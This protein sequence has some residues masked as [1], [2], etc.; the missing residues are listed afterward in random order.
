M[1]IK[2][3]GV[4]V[5]HICV[6]AILFLT[7]TQYL[8]QQFLGLHVTSPIVLALSFIAIGSAAFSGELRAQ[9]SPGLLILSLAILA[10]RNLAQ[11]S[12][13]TQGSLVVLP[14]VILGL[15]V[16]IEIETLLRCLAVAGVV[17]I[18]A[19]S[20]KG[21]YLEGRLAL[22]DTNPIWI[23]RMACMAFLATLFTTP[24]RHRSVNWTIAASLTVTMWLTGSRGPILAAWAA[25]LLFMAVKS[26]GRIRAL[27][28]VGILI[29]FVSENEW[30][31]GTGLP[32]RSNGEINTEWRLAAWQQ[33]L[34]LWSSRPVLGYGVAFDAQTNGVEAYPHNAFIELL[35]QTGVVGLGIFAF[36]LWLTWRGN[37][38]PMFRSIFVAVLIFSAF[39][40][41]IWS[42]YELWLFAL[43]RAN[44][45]NDRL[46]ERPAQVPVD[47]A[48]DYQGPLD[49]NEL[50]GPMRASR[51]HADQR[52]SASPV[53]LKRPGPAGGPDP[54]EDGVLPTPNFCS[55]L[56]RGGSERSRPTSGAKEPRPGPVA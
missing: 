27:S 55:D 46:I 43:L 11:I 6:T 44:S 19:L 25:I 42:A 45:R 52:L 50:P 26:A 48:P 32:A 54:T 37:K 15:C 14:I 28:V 40:G 23:A 34:H 36:I 9:W 3:A 13:L 4:L 12:P 18:V 31:G 16:R 33:A 21:E 22:P 56:I 5:T 49:L 2:R 53:G 47:P 38:S 41:S 10:F 8:V 35:V 24:I 17:L 39:S 1:T 7:L 30:L 51:I 29:V 20:I